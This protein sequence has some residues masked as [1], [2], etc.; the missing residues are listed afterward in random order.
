[1]I[2]AYSLALLV[3]GALLFLLEPMVGKFV[4]PLLGSAPEVWPMVR[5]LTPGAPGAPPGVELPKTE[6]N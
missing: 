6:R 4:L 5:V 1:M 2:V 3:S